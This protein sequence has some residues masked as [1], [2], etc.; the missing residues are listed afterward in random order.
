MA[1][2]VLEFHWL[3]CM[4]CLTT[5]GLE[6]YMRRKHGKPKASLSQGHFVWPFPKSSIL[7]LFEATDLWDV[8][9]L[10][11]ALSWLT[12]T[13]WKDAADILTSEHFQVAPPITQGPHHSHWRTYP[14]NNPAVLSLY[15]ANP[16]NYFIELKTDK[17]TK[18]QNQ[19]VFF[20]LTH[21]KKRTS[22][23]IVSV[24][25]RPSHQVTLGRR[26]VWT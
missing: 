15:Y 6:F 21:L 17:K 26:L 23:L 20:P 25:R 12:A 3:T 19:A 14:Q 10:A 2:R 1:L 7:W 4:D 9:A 24:C 13:E 18:T 5:R 16:L 8:H 11:V 22:P